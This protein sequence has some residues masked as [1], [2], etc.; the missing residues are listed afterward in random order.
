MSRL[1][2]HRRLP[3]V[4]SKQI[5]ELDNVALIRLSALWPARNRPVPRTSCSK[6]ESRHGRVPLSGNDL[7]SLPWSTQ[8]ALYEAN[9]ISAKKP[10]RGVT[11]LVGLGDVHKNTFGT[12]DGNVEQPP[13]GVH[14]GSTVVR[15]AALA[16]ID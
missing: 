8:K 15:E 3:N 6:N 12:R 4:R 14:V 2:E 7:E 5:L 10:R 16:Q 11:P 1:W 13:L 9:T